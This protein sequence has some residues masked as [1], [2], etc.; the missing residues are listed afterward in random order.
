[1]EGNVFLLGRPGSGKSSAAGLIEMFAGDWGWTTHYMN[2]YELL[3]KMFLQEIA[4]HTPRERRKFR[5]TGPEECN[6]FDVT[7]FS[8]LD[9]VLEKM[10]GE[11]EEVKARALEEVNTLCLVEFAR[12]SYHDA[13]QLFGSDLL[14]GAHLLYLDVDIES[15]IK[16]NHQ[17]TDHFVSDDIMRTYYLEDDWVHVSLNIQ[18]SYGSRAKTWEIK[19]TGSFQDF[20]QTIEEWVNTRL[21][22]ELVGI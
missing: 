13:F 19:N 4:Q 12:A 20:T 15:C 3:Q 22:R 2:D 10:K 14:Q 9:T 11:V 5:S 7:N 21:I 17:R 18:Q 6:G 1:M 8:V 16:H